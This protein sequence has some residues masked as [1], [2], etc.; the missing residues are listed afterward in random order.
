MAKR[1]THG[2][3]ASGKPI[4]E[5]MVEKLAKKAEAGYDVE[6]TLRRRPGRPAIGSAP[7]SV[8]SVRLEPELRDALAKRADR[9]DETTSTVIRKALRQYLRVG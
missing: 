1:K 8:E 9:D 3:T 2:K 4:T 5:E 7:A 6:E